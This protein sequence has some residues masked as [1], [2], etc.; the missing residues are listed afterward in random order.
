MMTVIPSVYLQPS[1]SKL[2]EFDIIHNFENVLWQKLNKYYGKHKKDYQ[3]NKHVNNL[4]YEL[5]N[6]DVFNKD[7]IKQTAQ[8]VANS[9]SKLMVIFLIKDLLSTKLT[10]GNLVIG[11]Y[12]IIKLCKCYIRLKK[13]DNIKYIIDE[14]KSL[15][16]SYS[17]SHNI[18][19]DLT[20]ATTPLRYSFIIVSFSLFV[21]S[22]YSII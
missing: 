20:L 16:N 5:K 10:T 3:V 13:E 15:L 17:T 11:V 21:V 22:I 1:M 18:D 2:S 6:I 19:H 7:Y 12:F 4:R 9:E 14:T 8:I